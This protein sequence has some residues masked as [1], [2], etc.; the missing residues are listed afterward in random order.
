MATS[1]HIWVQGTELRYVDGAGSVRAQTGTTT[2]QTGTAGFIWIEGEN[3]RY[4]DSVGA[5]RILPR[6][7][8]TGLGT[9]GHLWLEGAWVHYINPAANT[10]TRWH[11]DVA[12]I[13]TAHSNWSNH[14]NTAHSNWSNHSNVAAHSD[15]EHGDSFIE[16][17]PVKAPPR[18]F[19]AVTKKFIFPQE[20]RAFPK[21]IAHVD[22]PHGD[23]P[24]SNW[25]NHSNTAH[26]NWSNHSNTA[27]SNVT[28]QD[29]P[30]LR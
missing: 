11:T 10:K 22:H 17:Q 14:S 19:L 1:G 8:L 24:H 4:T 2:G 25:S 13:N 23:T 30:S 29:E 20:A 28:H 27:H 15:G 16:P 5:V 21:K 9:A 12:H 6:E 3:L 7:V 26:S 18:D